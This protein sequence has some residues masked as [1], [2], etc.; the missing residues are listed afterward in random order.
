MSLG[1]GGFGGGWGPRFPEW[2][3][4][5]G[6]LQASHMHI[7]VTAGKAGKGRGWQERA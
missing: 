1:S 4:K 5:A 7:A 2:K 3:S 6:S